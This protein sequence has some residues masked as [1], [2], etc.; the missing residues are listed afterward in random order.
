M[1][2]IGVAV[3][4]DP[5]GAGVAVGTSPEPSLLVWGTVSKPLSTSEVQAGI[6]VL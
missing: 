6:Q 4:A 3:G 1:V 2:G 5:L